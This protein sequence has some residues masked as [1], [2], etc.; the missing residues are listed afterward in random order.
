MRD[1]TGREIKELRVRMAI[2]FGCLSTLQH[3]HRRGVDVD[4]VCPCAALFGNLELM[5]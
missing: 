1:A 5:N 3:L 2:K 4:I